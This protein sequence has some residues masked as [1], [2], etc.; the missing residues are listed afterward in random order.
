ML[1]VFGELPHPINAD[2]TVAIANAAL[3]ARDPISPPLE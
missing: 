3:D 1:V 2:A